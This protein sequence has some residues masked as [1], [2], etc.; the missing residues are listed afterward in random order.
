MSFTIS[1]KINHL[2]VRYIFSAEFKNEKYEIYTN[3]I[4]EMEFISET[5]P[6][7]KIVA[8]FKK[9]AV[10]EVKLKQEIRNIMNDDFLQSEISKEIKISFED[11]RVL[12]N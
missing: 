8:N 4:N 3:L 7:D 1:Y 2:T 5:T 6:I 10:I 9:I 11:G 12:R